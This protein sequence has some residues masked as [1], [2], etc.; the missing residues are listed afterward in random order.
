[1]KNLPKF[2]RLLNSNEKGAK[3]KKF[4]Y[5]NE[6][7]SEDE[8]LSSSSEDDVQDTSEKL[9]VKPVVSDYVVVKFTGKKKIHHY[10]GQIESVNEFG[11]FNISFLKKSATN[12]GYVFPEV[13]DK[14]CH[15]IND[16]VL[17]LPQPHPV[18][19][20]WRCQNVLAF[21]SA[22]LVDFDPQ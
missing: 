9:I 4:N 3:R 1:M 2:R 16:I 11:E 12:A 8:I 7:S 21:S 17:L 6:S 20:T 22:H 18:G 14:S 10:I 5:V 13:P 19:G 15:S